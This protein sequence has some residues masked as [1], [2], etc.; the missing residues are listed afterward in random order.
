M[1]PT[2]DTTATLL[3][4]LLAVRLPRRMRCACCVNFEADAADAPWGECMDDLQLNN[5]QANDRCTA[6]EPLRW[7]WYEEDV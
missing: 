4:A 7:E 1:M 6:W 3:A 5:V 2:D